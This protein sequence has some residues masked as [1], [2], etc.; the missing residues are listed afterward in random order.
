[1]LLHHFGDRR[2][3]LVN[4][5]EVAVDARKTYV[6]DLI[7]LMKPLHH[8]LSELL[9]RYL[10]SING[11]NDIVKQVTDLIVRHRTVAAG[12]A[13]TLLK[14]AAVERL[15]A[16]IALDDAH[17]VAINLL[18]RREAASAGCTFATAAYRRTFANA[19]RIQ[20]LIFIVSALGTLHRY[21]ALLAVGAHRAMAAIEVHRHGRQITLAAGVPFLVP[22]ERGKD[23]SE[24][25]KAA[26]RENGNSDEFTGKLTDCADENEGK[27]E[28]NAGAES[29]S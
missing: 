20:H 26:R 8:E 23:E 17:L 25:D 12:Y 2:K 4:V 1:M 16:T 14:L 19:T 11:G 29:V 9:R 13:D 24:H 15:A 27:P 22:V 7:Y 28:T 3:E 18:V 10:I 5:R 6:S 21:K